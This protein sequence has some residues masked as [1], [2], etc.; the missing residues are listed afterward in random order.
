MALISHFLH[1]R[2]F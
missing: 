2:I 1:I